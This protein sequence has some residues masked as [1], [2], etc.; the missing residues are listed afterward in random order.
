MSVTV[1][2][3]RAGGNFQLSAE[4]G[5]RFPALISATGR[6]IAAYAYA[7]SGP[8]ESTTDLVF[9]GHCLIA[10]NG[11]L[12]SESRRVGDGGDL[13]RESYFITADVDVKA[14]DLDYRKTIPLGG[15]ACCECGDCCDPCGDPCGCGDTCC[16]P[17]CPAWDITW[18]GGLRFADVNWDRYYL[19][20]D[21]GHHFRSGS[22][23]VLENNVLEI[24][25]G[26]DTSRYSVVELT[27]EVLLQVGK[28]NFLK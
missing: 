4:V 28:R 12:I 11:T 21:D 2:T 7:G 19:A 1:A 27:D 22:W 5:S 8:T 24:E 20:P 3:A 9:G 10:E 15:P 13:A 17:G 26:D 23:R 14:F 16:S 25:K 18:S 6:C